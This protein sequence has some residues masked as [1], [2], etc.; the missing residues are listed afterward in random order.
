MY[1]LLPNLYSGNNLKLRPQVCLPHCLEVEEGGGYCSLPSKVYIFHLCRNLRRVFFATTQH[2]YSTKF[3]KLFLAVC[4]LYFV[5]KAP[6]PR[7]LAGGYRSSHGAC[8]RGVPTAGRS[9]LPLRGHPLP[10]GRPAHRLPATPS[11]ITDV[12][13]SWNLGC[14]ASSDLHTGLSGREGGGSSQMDNVSGQRAS[15]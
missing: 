10:R 5:L 13:V 4:R 14:S 6:P 1:F 7:C 3:P 2:N 11:P 12:G 15:P 9:L 8:S